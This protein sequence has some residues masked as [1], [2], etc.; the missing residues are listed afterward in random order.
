[1][2]F[3]KL[4]EMQNENNKDKMGTMLEMTSDDTDKAKMTCARKRT[5]L[6]MV[7]GLPKFAN[8]MIDAYNIEDFIAYPEVLG[9]FSFF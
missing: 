1:M 5:Q 9:I 7:D 6:L 3:A 4:M 8:V 2:N